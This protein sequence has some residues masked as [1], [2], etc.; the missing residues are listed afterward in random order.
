[1]KYRFSNYAGKKKEYVRLVLKTEDPLLYRMGDALDYPDVETG[2]LDELVNAFFCEE[3]RKARAFGAWLASGRG[4]A[5]VEDRAAAS[6]KGMRERARELFLRMEETDDEEE[7]AELNSSFTELTA[8]ALMTE[9]AF[10]FRNPWYAL[11]NSLEDP[12]KAVW[13]VVVHAAIMDPAWFEHPVYPKSKNYARFGMKNAEADVRREGRSHGR[14]SQNGKGG[15]P[16]N[17][18]NMPYKEPVLKILSYEPVAYYEEYRN[19]LPQELL[20]KGIAEGGGENDCR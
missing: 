18:L 17:P 12:V 11:Y 14:G 1:M 10:T 3:K 20:G 5:P 9:Q 4:R 6:L 7:L 16:R 2:V 8:K 19:I 15:R 13:M